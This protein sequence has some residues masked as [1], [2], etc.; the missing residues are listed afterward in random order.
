LRNALLVN[1]QA[2]RLLLELGILEPPLPVQRCLALAK[3][4]V[5]DFALGEM[6]G[7]NAPEH[8]HDLVLEH[9]LERTFGLLDRRNSLVYLQANMTHGRQ[10]FVTMHEVGHQWLPWQR[11][12]GT[13]VD[14]EK[15]I[16]LDTKDLY[17]WQANVFA[18]EML[19]LRDR[20]SAEAFDLPF[21]LRTVLTLATRFETSVH[22]ALRRYVESHK[23]R[24]M[25]LV[26]EREPTVRSGNSSLRVKNA[27]FSTPFLQM[28]R[29]WKAP[30]WVLSSDMHDFVGR[31]A[32]SDLRHEL[33][34]D[35]DG[36]VIPVT[37]QG[38]DNGFDILLFGRP[39]DGQQLPRRQRIRT[40]RL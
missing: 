9:A 24:C 27:F 11:T 14:G 34:I 8:I 2:D 22:A 23:Q 31:T 21:D 12:H 37:L 16:D 1:K 36:E 40:I 3:L 26:L 29:R 28:Y 32:P 5:A 20:F 13:H 39:S 15:N 4:T 17:E 7:N 30:K 25:M 6:P 38:L 33:T 10:N 18:S 19:F 35:G